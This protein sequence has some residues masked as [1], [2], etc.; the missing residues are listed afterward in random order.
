M[1][2]YNL[3]GQQIQGYRI[4]KKL[5]SGGYGTVYLGEKEDLGKTY[6]TAIKHISMPN[7]EGYESV[8]QD[9][10]YDK[11]AAQ[12]HFEKMVEG[13]TAEINTLLAL[14]KKDNRHIVAYY[15]H[16][17][18]R[19]IDPL[20][21]DIF[22]RMEYLTPLNRHIREKGMTLG[23]IIRL[24]L[25]MC[26]ALSLCHNSGVMHR[27][28]KEAN[29]FI[30][31]DGS[32]KLGD[33]GVA[34]TAIETTQAGS[35]KG[36]ASYM[37]PEIYLREPY[38]NSVDIYSLG[39]VLY[40]LLNHQRLPFMPEAPA[41]FTVDDK[42]LAETRRL[43]GETPPLPA[44]A[45]NRLGEIVV[46]ACS[47]KAA[48]YARAEALK[49]DLQGVLKSLSN[50]DY[51]SV[52]IPPSPEGEQ[53]GGVYPQ[54]SPENTYTQTQGAT[55]TMGAQNAG[56]VP[57]PAEQNPYAKPEKPKKE[58]K[59]GKKKR[60]LVPI[61]IILIAVAC[62]AVYILYSKFTDPVNQFQ[63]AIM[64]NDF[65]GA[66]QLYLDEIKDGDAKKLEQAEQF[67]VSHA[68]EVKA[69]YT[70][71]EIEYEDA[72]AQLQEMG[73][74]GIVGSGELQPMIETVNELR[75][76]RAAYEN[77]QADI[78]SGDWKSAIGELRKVIPSDA[79]YAQAQTQLADAIRSYKDEL[80]DSM[81]DYTLNGDYDEAIAALRAGLQVVPDD[82]DLLAKITDLE[83]QISDEIDLAV[84]AIIQSASGA[85][86]NSAD[87]KAALAELRDAA[88]QYPN[89]DDLKDAIADMEQNY[90]TFVFD[91]VDALVEEKRFDDAVNQLNDLKKD[92]SDGAAVDDKIAQVNDLRPVDLSR[93]VVIDSQYY[94][95]SAG[96]FTDSFGYTHDGRHSFNCASDGYAVFNL[97]GQYTTFSGT[98][99]SSQ[100]TDSDASMDI[101]VYVD[102]K[103]VYS[104]TGFTKR[105]GAVDF[106]VD[107]RG[108]TKLGIYTDAN[109]SWK[110]SNASIV[111]TRLEK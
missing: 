25:N 74:L 4:V 61:A 57:P 23:E 78:E 97:A 105:T 9:Y 6:Q 8:L 35:I 89:R 58:K 10:G 11:A 39:I 49:A 55:I 66:A 27:D 109:S 52:I 76:S 12:A 77:A 72:L 42:N 41:P 108:V 103:L 21:Y 92:I 20:R 67:V 5:G 46:K 99:V 22:L 101:A 85:A 54:V 73:K 43:K 17:I 7:A 90:L 106:S 1:A 88:K 80:L 94:S 107:V 51:D 84:A 38:D 75:T 87:Y 2:E 47:G 34:K 96:I 68:E 82:A 18:Q 102:D 59:K 71:G 50:E 111:N 36:T 83:K 28:I 24:G 93:V 70:N 44:Q 98:I 40:K 33:F 95:Y 48:R 64:G 79:D 110:T 60:V 69:Q 65:S 86:A 31:E 32:F 14:S 29:I 62:A 16:S 81:S 104:K 15:D 3:I 56:A 19:S 53:A 30:S 45:K 63:D 26:E 100:N 91:S 13:I 37:A